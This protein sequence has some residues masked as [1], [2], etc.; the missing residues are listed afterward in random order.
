MSDGSEPLQADLSR[1]TLDRVNRSEQAIDFFRIVVALQR[2]Q[3]IADNLKMLFGFGLKKLKNF[4]ADFVIGWK[5]VEI[6]AGDAGL[7]R[8]G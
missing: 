2:N 4:G 8:F 7:R 3:A 5:R 1:R 6:G